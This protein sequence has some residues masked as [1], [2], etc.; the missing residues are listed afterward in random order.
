MNIYNLTVSGIINILSILNKI[1]I[2]LIATL[3]TMVLVAFILMGTPAFIAGIALYSTATLTLT[4]TIIPAIILSVM[5][6]S[7]L[8]DVF[9]ETGDKSPN[10]PKIKKRTFS[11]L[12][13][14]LTLNQCDFPLKLDGNWDYFSTLSNYRIPLNLLT[15]PPESIQ[16]LQVQDDR[17]S[18]TCSFELIH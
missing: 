3:M 7:I 9:N 14:F 10:K 5:M 6:N 18:C 13:Y 8:K 17:I 1:L 12:F 15:Y 2:G 16:T 4:V 11:P